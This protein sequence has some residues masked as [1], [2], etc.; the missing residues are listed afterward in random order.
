[1]G[2]R[3][4]S[5]TRERVTASPLLLLSS[6]LSVQR[7]YSEGKRGR[8]GG[9]LSMRVCEKGER[10]QPCGEGGEGVRERVTGKRG[11]RTRTARDPICSHGLVL[12]RYKYLM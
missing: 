6:L 5:G 11:K 10:E 12:C 3:R 9:M 8:G 7:M 1:M 4:G 2:K